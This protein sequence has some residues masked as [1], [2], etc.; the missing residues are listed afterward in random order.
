MHRNQSSSYHACTQ[1][2][3]AGWGGPPTTTT[4]TRLASPAHHHVCYAYVP[5]KAIRLDRAREHEAHNPSAQSPGLSLGP[6]LQHHARIAMKHLN[7]SMSRPI[8]LSIA[9]QRRIK[10]R[11]FSLRS[12]LLS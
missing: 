8:G 6:P 9:R 3:A 7:V 2:I 10:H 1:D 5:R 4:T 12:F 11:R